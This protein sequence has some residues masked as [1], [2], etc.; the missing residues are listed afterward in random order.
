MRLILATVTIALALGS[1]VMPAAAGGDYEY[2]GSVKDYGIAGVPVPAPVPLP[3]YEAEWYLRFDAGYDFMPSGD[4]SVSGFP[5]NPQNL[6][7]NSGTFS[8]SAGF[9]RYLT[10]SLRWDIQVDI[11]NGRGITA[12]DGAITQTITR[13]GPTVVVNSVSLS[14]NDIYNYE[15]DFRHRGRIETDTAMFNL[16]KD[17]DTGHRIKPYVGAGIGIAQHYVKAT[18][19]GTLDCRDMT[20]DVVFDPGSGEGGFQ[21]TGLACPD[22]ATPIND[23]YTTS[24]TGYS[25]SLALMAGVSMEL[26]KGITL[27]T[28]YRFTYMPGTVALIARTPLTPS[29]IDVGDRM[30]HE[31]RTGLRFD[32]D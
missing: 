24:T 9:G 3:I 12:Y 14:S 13:P 5:I 21:I 7:D 4:V 17:F 27:D 1:A 29:L 31:F 15:G 20:R 8:F 6:G 30:G 25:L 26:R 2:G 11:R 32:I 19:T 28:G 10:P 18:G 16:Y 22:E 23:N